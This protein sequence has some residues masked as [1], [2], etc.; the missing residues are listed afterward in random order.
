VSPRAGATAYELTRIGLLAT[1]PGETIARLAQRMVRDAIAPGAS[2]VE[3]GDRSDRFYVVLS[4]ILGVSQ[5]SQ[6]PRR[7]LR[8]GDYFGEVAPA[9]DIPRTATVRALTPAVVASC[10]RETFDEFIRPLFADDWSPETAAALVA[11]DAEFREIPGSRTYRGPQGTRENFDF[12]LGAF[13][14]GKVEITNLVDAGE[15]V[16]VEYKGRGTNTGT[17]QIEGGAIPPTGKQVQLEF[18]DVLQ[19]KGGKIAGGRSYYDAASMM[20]QLGLVPETVAAGA[21]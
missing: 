16:V 15:T 7:M 17:L 1:L 13:P 10:D 18:C 12:W 3:E 9:L 11:E 21:R 5:V 8:A 4:G 19:F 2:I 14:D 20:Q 6:G